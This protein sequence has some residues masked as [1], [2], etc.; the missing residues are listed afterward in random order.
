ME[1]L[2]GFEVT[3][4]AAVPD[5]ADARFLFAGYLVLDALVA[6]TDRH[7]VPLGD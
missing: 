2:T 5:G 4:G 3:P 1:A 7:H 6:N